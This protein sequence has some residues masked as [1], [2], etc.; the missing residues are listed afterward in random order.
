MINP[1]NV[2]IVSHFITAS[3][4]LTVI[5]ELWET[6]Q[7]MKTSGKGLLLLLGDAHLLGAIPW[8]IYVFIINKASFMNVLFPIA[9]GVIL[10][11]PL[12]LSTKFISTDKGSIRFKRSIFL[13]LFLIGIPFLRRFVGF[14]WFFKKHPVFFPNTHFPNI[15]LMIVMYVT[16]LVVN[17]YVWRIVSYLK[18]K[19]VKQE[20]AKG[21]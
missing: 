20:L 19:Q 12:I 6:T 2:N 17:I 9:M 16:V 4:I 18:F 13:P 3:I 5:V 21:I 11:I 14:S 10:A 7:P 15:E 1:Q 8:I